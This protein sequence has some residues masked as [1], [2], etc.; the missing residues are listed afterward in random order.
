MARCFF[1]HQ[2][3]DASLRAMFEP[4]F[5]NPIFACFLAFLDGEPAGGGGLQIHDGVAQMGGAGTLPEYRHRGVQNALFH[6]RL[7]FALGAGC[8]LA[9]TMAQPGTTSHRNAERR[10]FRVL[11]TRSKFALG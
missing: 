9:D 6:A 4:A 1:E 8:D 10:G 5:H 7:E 3:I 11:Y 2:E